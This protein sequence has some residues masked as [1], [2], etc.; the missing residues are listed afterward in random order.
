MH[1]AAALPSRDIN[2]AL[3]RVRAAAALRAFNVGDYALDIWLADDERMRSL[4]R[5]H[6]GKDR[7]TDVLSFPYAHEHVTRA[8]LSPG[9]LP[10]PTSRADARLGDVFVGIAAAR[11]AAVRVPSG[12]A[13]DPAGLVPAVCGCYGR[14]YAAAAPVGV[15]DACWLLA[16]HGICHLLG[17]THEDVADTAAMIADEDSALRAAEHAIA[18][19]G[20]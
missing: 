13:A 7:T 3:L 2:A 18:A 14:L 6:R 15:D 8:F 1:R 5:T 17:H 4:N 11:S 12:C 16:V 19:R 10:L 20:G 9:A